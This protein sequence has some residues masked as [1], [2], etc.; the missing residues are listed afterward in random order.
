MIEPA[1]ETKGYASADGLLAALDERPGM[2]GWN[3]HAHP[4]A[5]H[6]GYIFRGQSEAEWGLVPR[7][8]RR[9]F[10]WWQFSSLGSWCNEAIDA[11]PPRT[12]LC[13]IAWMMSMELRVVR[14]FLEQADNHGLVQRAVD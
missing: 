8:F 9:D 14:E 12:R 10:S 7:V 13:H 6:Q 11:D 4:Q 2:L 3:V 1:F 5:G